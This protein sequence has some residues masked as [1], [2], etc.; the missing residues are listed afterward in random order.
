MIIYWAGIAT[1]L[2]PCYPAPVKP[3]YTLN[4]IRTALRNLDDDISNPDVP[5]DGTRARL[6]TITEVAAQAL[7]A[8]FHPLPPERM[9]ALARAVSA[10]QR[11]EFSEARR[12]VLEAIKDPA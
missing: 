12:L 10:V 3:A 2:P 6:L 9:A 4:V 7:Q 11:D 8:T 1:S 5:W